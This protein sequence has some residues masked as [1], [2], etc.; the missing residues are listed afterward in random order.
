MCESD[1]ISL[2]ICNC[3]V[4]CNDFVGALLLALESTLVHFCPGWHWDSSL[5]PPAASAKGR[6]SN[7]HSVELAEAVSRPCP[8]DFPEE[9]LD[10]LQKDLCSQSFS[11]NSFEST[12]GNPQAYDSRHVRPR[13]HFSRSWNSLLYWG[14]SWVLDCLHGLQPLVGWGLEREPSHHVYGET[15]RERSRLAHGDPACAEPIIGADEPIDANP[16]IEADASN[17]PK[18]C[19]S[20]DGPAWTLHQEAGRIDNYVP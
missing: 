4:M 19:K 8:L 10:K 14:Y 2:P 12:A 5:V 13:E 3:I 1:P 15:P 9:I 17:W 7:L 11:W 18:P 16:D 20:G 6:Q